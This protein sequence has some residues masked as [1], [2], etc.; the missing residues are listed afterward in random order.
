MPPAIIPKCP[1]H[2]DKEARK[3][4]RR[5]TKELE[6]LGMLAKIDMAV[7]ASYCLAYSMWTNATLK[8]Q[9]QG[10][11]FKTPGKTTTKIMKDGTEKTEQTGGGYP[12]INPWWTVINKENEKMMKALVEIGMSPSSRSRVK[13]IPKPKKDEAEEFLREGKGG[14]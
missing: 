2:L 14:K 9:E 5:T 12:M 8:L 11:I 1:R 7:L 6:P 13:V 3:E 10:M 4:W